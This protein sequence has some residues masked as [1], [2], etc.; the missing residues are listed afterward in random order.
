MRLDITIIIFRYIEKQGKAGQ[1]HDAPR[2]AQEK[3]AADEHELERGDWRDDSPEIGGGSSRHG[4]GCHFER[5]GEAAGSKE[6]E[7]PEGD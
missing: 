2:I 4:E 3:I 7:R 1:N 5:E 6:L